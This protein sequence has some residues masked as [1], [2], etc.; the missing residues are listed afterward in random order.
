ME[1]RE[2]STVDLLTGLQFEKMIAQAQTQV[3]TLVDAQAVYVAH[4]RERYE[5][6][7]GWD[8]ENWAQGFVRK[9]E[10]ETDDGN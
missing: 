4:L 2:L 7:D 9:V 1:Q 8:F 5:C 3:Q 10:E 6:G